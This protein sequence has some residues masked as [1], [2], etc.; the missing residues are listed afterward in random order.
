MLIIFHQKGSNF[1][2]AAHIQNF[3]NSGK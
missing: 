1:E 3:Y 2:G